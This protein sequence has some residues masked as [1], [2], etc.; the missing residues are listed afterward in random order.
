[1]KPTDSRDGLVLDQLPLVKQIARQI[2]YRVPKH[3]VFEDLVQAGIVGLLDA[4]EKYDCN[5]PVKFGSY[6]KIR[7]RG[8]ILDSLRDMDSGTRSLRKFARRAEQAREVLRAEF[9][10]EPSEAEIAEEMEM[11]LRRFQLSR[12]DLDCLTTMSFRADAEW[13]DDPG[14]LVDY[15]SSPSEQS[16]YALVLREEMVELLGKLLT[17]LPERQREVLALYYQ[18]SLTMKEIGAALGVGESRVSQL[19]SSAIAGLRSRLQALGATTGA[20][21]ASR[22]LS[23]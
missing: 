23:S 9:G 15:A 22:Y 1:M 4:C 10:R 5:R 17:E 3:V 6:A 16:P 18:Q 11:S 2:Y 19:H 20:V 7:I 12:R 21:T 8:S 14:Q 13:D